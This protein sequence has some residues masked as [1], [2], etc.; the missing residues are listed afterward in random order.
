MIRNVMYLGTDI[1]REIVYQFHDK[2]KQVSKFFLWNIS[3]ILVASRIT[4]I[5]LS[6]Y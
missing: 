6:Y 4:A 1:D 5:K 2:Q 3:V